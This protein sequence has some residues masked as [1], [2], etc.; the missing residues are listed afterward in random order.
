MPYTLYKDYLLT[1]GF[2]KKISTF[3]SLTVEKT[4]VVNVILRK[5]VY[6]VTL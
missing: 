5:Y 6:Y 1:I 3:L 4:K 2:G